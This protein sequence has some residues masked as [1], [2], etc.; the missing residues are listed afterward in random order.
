MVS[1]LQA[2]GID[3]QTQSR[4]NSIP[5]VITK[6][7]KNECNTSVTLSRMMLEESLNMQLADKKLGLQEN[8]E[9]QQ[10]LIMSSGPVEDKPRVSNVTEN[11]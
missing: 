9:K 1:R 4:Q 7:T 5:F 11:L 6:Q 8:E 2:E 10:S 3:S